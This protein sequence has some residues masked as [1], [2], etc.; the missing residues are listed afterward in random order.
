MTGR[1]RALWA[2]L[3]AGVAAA[4]AIATP[5]VFAGITLTGLD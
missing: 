4:A 5:A 3:F 2:V 1:I